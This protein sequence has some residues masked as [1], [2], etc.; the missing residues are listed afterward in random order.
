MR[1][2]SLHI[3]NYGN[4]SNYDYTFDNISSFCEDN[5]YGKTTITSF[6][7]AMFYGL[8]T[9][10]KTTKDFVDRKH[11]YPFKG[12]TFG[13]NIVFEYND[14]EYR[15][16]RTF[17]EKSATEDTLTVYCKNRETDE[18]G[19]VP[20]ETIF[21]IKKESFERLL[22]INAD[23]IQI[24][25]STDI[26]QKLNN[27]V[28][29]VGEEFNI[30]NVLK[31][32]KE[33]KKECTTKK[34]S[35]EE[36]IKQDRQEI[37]GLEGVKAALDNKYEKLNKAEEE[38]READKNYAYAATQGTIIANWKNYEGKLDDANQKK[39][40]FEEI[41]SKYP[42]GIPTE[43][44]YNAL[45]DANKR[46]SEIKGSLSSHGINEEQKAK[47]E[48]LKSKFSKHMPTDEELSKVDEKILDYDKACNAINS[49][50]VDKKTDKELELEKHF[51]GEKIS[52]DAI[53]DIED[54]VNK[55]ESLE[56]ELKGINPAIIEKQ[57]KTET[58]KKIV[59]KGL[60][61]GLIILS[62]V[63]LGAG[64]GLMFV[65]VPVAIALLVLGI[66]LLIGD[67]FYYF[68][69]KL[70][71]ITNTTEES[72]EK[73]NPAYE[74][75]VK[76]IQALNNEIFRLLA[77]YRYN[78]ENTV[79]LFFQFKTDAKEYNSILN[80]KIDNTDLLKENED[81]KNSIEKELIEYFSN[82]NMSL[83]LSY[84]FLLSSLRKEVGE[85]NTLTGIMDANSKTKKELEEKKG[86]NETIIKDFYSKY[87]ITSDCS[88]ESIN[89]DIVDFARLNMEYNEKIELA[90][91]FK[92]ENNLDEKPENIDFDLD[93]LGAIKKEK[94]NEFRI[95][96]S[97]IE[98]DEEKIQKIDELNNRVA[99]N[100]AEKDENANKAKLFESLYKEI[101][102]ADE[103]LKEKYVA[104]IKN[105]FCY[106]A[107]L[108]EKA[109]GEKV[110]MDSNYRVSFDREG[111]L[112]SFE[113]LSSGYLAICALCFRLALIDNIFNGEL[114]FIIL[115]DPFV[116]L[117]AKKLVKAI[118]LIN[119]LSENKQIIYFC[120]HES[121]KLN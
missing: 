116:N 118:D 81:N 12:G 39:K 90:N 96:K 8:E 71:S 88:I 40:S 48:L 78:G 82:F 18:L 7:M 106:Y 32:I 80:S 41:A 3:T 19:D 63:L 16:E 59:N 22:L 101:T 92:T 91:K 58:T 51:F 89:R 69:T 73:T 25:S 43:E 26:N 95:L 33:K 49:L 29:N 36:S 107:E 87:G 115:D 97:D 11:F 74:A 38:S 21:G 64:I 112:R 31:K 46:L 62:I 13:G 72:I 2:K 77:N 55:C 23:K 27:Y 28:E 24:E 105:R 50:T 94:F 20:G 30:D 60:F 17:T 98:D 61:I 79:M 53:K 68:N 83:N 9:Y 117:D 114:P 1:L 4:L 14:A 54:K 103:S 34:A 100:V 119:S 65:M 76:E 75:K 121:R 66:G 10:K 57:E 44:D 45:T 85:Y 67:M 93:E 42:K 86:K 84:K 70:K 47:Y 15:I 6:I 109:I 52:D 5:G 104:P 102:K 110:K 56:D 111:A 99:N 113:H 37:R 120:C 35:L 108:L